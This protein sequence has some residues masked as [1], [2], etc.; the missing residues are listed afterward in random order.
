MGIRS[1]VAV[2]VS[3]VLV[4]FITLP[5][6]DAV[7][8]DLVWEQ[9]D[10][11]ASI[12]LALYTAPDGG[13]VY[14]ADEGFSVHAYDALTGELRWRG[15]WGGRHAITY[16]SAMSPDGSALFLVGD[17][18]N[19]SDTGYETVAFDTSTGER[20]WARYGEFFASSV[21]ASPD[22][23]TVFVTGARGVIAYRASTGERIWVTKFGRP[24]DGQDLAVGAN[25]RRVYVIGETPGSSNHVVT[26]AY[27][28]R[29]G[30]EVWKRRFSHRDNWS[31]SARRVAV[32]ASRVFVIGSTSPARG[33]DSRSLTLAYDAVTGRSLWTRLNNDSISYDYPH[34]VVIDPSTGTVLVL[35]ASGSDTDTGYDTVTLAY[36]LA[37][38][39]TRWS[40]RYEGEIYDD[41]NDLT[42]DPQTGTGYEL[43]TVLGDGITE[44]DD[45]ALMAYD[46]SSGGLE[47]D[48]R[49]GGPGLPREQADAL[50]L[51][52]TGDVLYVTGSSADGQGS[53]DTV[54]LAYATT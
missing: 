32:D 22:S 8:G 29:I 3:I 43:A 15:S 7:P 44:W 38:G 4:S 5:S 17:R 35:G 53:Y 51:S 50:A 14:M 54:V 26:I 34:D 23:S 24:F 52:P 1:P 28:T 16:G 36:D 30:R 27:S 33:V 11:V 40:A 42:L 41:P 45:F 47:W 21:A 31:V 48:A 18:N 39:D 9:R 46:T 2:L 12:A 20:I 49:Y 37:T 10:L 6:A 25:G 19:F 13:T